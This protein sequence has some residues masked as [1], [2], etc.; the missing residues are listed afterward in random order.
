MDKIYTGASIFG[1][2]FGKE[3]EIRYVSDSNEVLITKVQ[4]RLRASQ[5][6]V[7]LNE[8]FF[9]AGCVG[10][11]PDIDADVRVMCDEKTNQLVIAR[12]SD[13]SVLPSFVND[14]AETTS[15]YHI[16]CVDMSAL[17]LENVCTII[18]GS[19]V[20]VEISYSPTKY[21]LYIVNTVSKDLPK[22]RIK[23]NEIFRCTKVI[24]GTTIHVRIWHSPDSDQIMIIC[25]PFIGASAATTMVV[26]KKIIKRFDNGRINTCEEFVDDTLVAITEHYYATG[27]VKSCMKYANDMLIMRDQF[28][29]AG[30][31]TS[32]YVCDAVTGEEIRCTYR[33]RGQLSA[34]L[35]HIEGVIDG[36]QHDYDSCGKKTSTTKYVMGEYV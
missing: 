36:D 30:I 34:R 27:I 1:N 21:E 6:R 12:I 19:D 35:R 2:I 10:R 11:I 28:N 17:R 5:L 29:E 14:V 15:G 7:G 18:P 32:S 31:K 33:P 22:L 4:A 25:S 9:D 20:K 24:P 13:T 3:I 8:I 26:P 16:L 23:M